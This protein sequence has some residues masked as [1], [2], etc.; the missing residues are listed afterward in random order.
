LVS[1]GEIPLDDKNAETHHGKRF[2]K[3]VPIGIV[4]GREVCEGEELNEHQEELQER[5][6]TPKFSDLSPEKRSG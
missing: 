3:D 1:K 2:Q 6:R 4:Q 5:I